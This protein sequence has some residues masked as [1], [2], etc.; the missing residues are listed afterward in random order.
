MRGK[1]R[2]E[3][4]FLGE[5]LHKN[6]FWS[7]SWM[8]AR[9]GDYWCV[10]WGKQ[11]SKCLISLPEIWISPFAFTIKQLL[12]ET[13]LPHSQIPQNMLRRA[14]GW[15]QCFWFKCFAFH[16]FKVCRKI[17]K[18][19]ILTGFPCAHMRTIRV[20]GTLRHISINTNKCAG[21]YLS[22]NG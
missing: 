5:R 19:G 16:P 7:A 11:L 3:E 14:D 1:R 10:S 21:E 18:K 12:S 9:D 8:V 4:G 22:D 15:V 6:C 2:R 17:P 20:Q 13:S